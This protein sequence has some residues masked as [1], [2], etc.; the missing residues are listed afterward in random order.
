MNTAGLSMSKIWP[1]DEVYAVSL[2]PISFL[3]GNFISS[4]NRDSSLIN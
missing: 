4:L 3:L 2:H 1:F